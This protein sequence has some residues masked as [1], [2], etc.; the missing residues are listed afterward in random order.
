MTADDPILADLRARL[1]ALDELENGPHAEVPVIRQDI[2]RLR[3]WI[4][5]LIEEHARGPEAFARALDE[6]R[7]A[8][9]RAL[10][11]GGDAFLAARKHLVVLPD[12]DHPEEVWIRWDTVPVDLRGDVVSL[13]S[14]FRDVISGRKI[15]RPK[16]GPLS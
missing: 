10:G 3:R 13:A 4:E 8:M 9:S 1:A 6:N 16:K 2:V 14:Y 15:G 7:P 5:T 12:D 11:G